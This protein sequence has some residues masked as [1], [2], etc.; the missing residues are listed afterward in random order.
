MLS[1][2]P[3]PARL[4]IIVLSLLSLGLAAPGCGRKEDANNPIVA[5]VGDSQIRRWDFISAV[6]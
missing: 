1:F 2:R 5:R 4:S 3:G 6:E